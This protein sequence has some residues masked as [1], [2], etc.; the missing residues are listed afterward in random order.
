MKVSDSQVD[1]DGVHREV[2]ALAQLTNPHIVRYYQSW[3]EDSKIG[4]RF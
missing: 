4:N 3:V 1:G 2:A